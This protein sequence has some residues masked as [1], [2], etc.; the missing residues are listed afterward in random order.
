MCVCLFLYAMRKGTDDSGDEAPSRRKSVGKLAVHS[1]RQTNKMR[2]DPA[3]RVRRQDG[4]RINDFID[5]KALRASF[6]I[7][8]RVFYRR[9]SLSLH[10]GWQ[11]QVNRQVTTRTIVNCHHAVSLVMR[12]KFNAKG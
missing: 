12:R 10:S 3:S 8:R 1:R 9:P 5:R 6:F 11:A 4:R 2:V 7:A